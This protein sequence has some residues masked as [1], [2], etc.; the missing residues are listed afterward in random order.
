MYNY[1]LQQARSIALT[2]D[3]QV[4]E[5]PE[6][7]IPTGYPPNAPEQILDKL[8]PILDF[9]KEL[10]DKEIQLTLMGP[11]AWNYYWLGST[12]ELKIILKKS[13]ELSRD[14]NQLYP[15][16]LAM[17]R[18]KIILDSEGEVEE[19]KKL[20]QELIELLS[21]R[22]DDSESGYL[23]FIQAN[24][25]NNSGQYALAID[26]YLKS[27]EAFEDNGN[28]N[29]LLDIYTQL[30]YAYETLEMQ[31]KAVDTYEKY[32]SIFKKLND[33]VGL[34]SAYHRPVLPLY[35]LKRY[36]EARKYMA[37][38]LQGA[39]E[40]S[41]PL[42]LAKSNMLE[43]QIL[44]DSGK[45]R[46]A[47]PYLQK[48]YET[49]LNSNDNQR[50]AEYTISFTLL[51]MAECYQKMGD[52]KSALKH[53][54]ECLQRENALKSERT[55]IKRKISFLISEIYLEM[56]QAEKAFDYLKMYQEII[57]MSNEAENTNRVAEAEIRSI[58]DKSEKQIE[59][60]EKERL[61]KI[62]ESKNQ[63]LW[64]FSI[65]GAL[66]SAIILSLVLYR[67]NKL[68]QKANA[69]LKEQ[70]E[71]IESTLEQLEATQTQLIQ[72]EKMASPG[73]LTAG[74]AHEIQN[75][76][77]FVNNFSEVNSELVEELREEVRKG[78]LE[79]VEAI[80][81]DIEENEQ[82]IKHH[83][84]RAEGIVKGMLQHSRTS[85]GEKEPTDLNALADE[86][87]RLAYHGLRAKDKSFNADFKTEFDPNLPK[88]NVIPQDIG[89]V[90][91]NLINNAFFAVSEKAA[92]HSDP[93]HSE[94]EES[95]DYQPEVIVSTRQ[96]DGKLEISVKDNG[97][98]IPEKVRD[99]IFQPFFTTKPTGS[100]TGLGLSL[101]YDIVKVHGGEMKVESLTADQAGKEE[102]GSLFIIQ[103]PI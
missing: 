49:Y 28:L 82:K 67:N 9:F 55:I 60:L 26:Y 88:I 62:Q 73:E 52:T 91:L 81:F 51:Y 38:A 72:S 13:A 27:A 30:G 31:D 11:M 25:Y 14:L 50:T 96:L 102:E 18:L 42:L 29:M 97:E 57:R 84:Q 98:G 85:Q 61:Q 90:L 15:E 100:G 32:I 103:L 99:K 64:I 2:V 39:N 45:Y 7:I 12:D 75:P 21:K 83:G 4:P 63:R 3:N 78:N 10:D 8:R 20:E 68:K 40:Q 5:Y 101:S 16:F 80:A 87:L 66:L 36:D 71:E 47:I 54:L 1:Y 46:A 89:R 58:I 56:G 34:Q 86:Y 43:G 35:E 23:K 69:Q 33:N 93:E 94:G 41:K 65:T 74:I 22:G 44:M 48:T 19:S 92:R 53:A 70:K 76:L 6:P 77:N 17:S 59:L 95:Y 79:E 24:Y 37:L